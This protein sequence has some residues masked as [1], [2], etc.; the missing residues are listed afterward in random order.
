MKKEQTAI[1]VFVMTICLIFTI[2][3]SGCTF[4][5]SDQPENNQVSPADLVT[6][7]TTQQVQP[8]STQ[9][10]VS[11]RDYYPDYDEQTK[12]GL[13]EDAKDEIVRLFPN[14]ERSELEGYWQDHESSTYGPP[15]IVFANVD[16]TS[17]KYM[18]IQKIRWKGLEQ[19]IHNNIV[20]VK[21]DPGS[22][23]VVFYGRESWYKPLKEEIRTVSIEEA[24]DKVLEFVRNA[25]GNDFIE[26][27]E[28]DFYIC[29]IDVDSS[30]GMGL[31]YIVLFNTYGGVQY[32]NDQIYVQYDLIEDVVRRYRDELKDPGLMKNLTTLS[33]VPT[34]SENEAKR[35][36]ET[37]LKESYPGEDLNI[38]YRILNGH[39]NS[40]NWYDQDELVY[41]DQ[42]DPIRLIW[43]ITFSDSE[44]RKEDSRKTTTAI[45]DAHT[46]EIVSLNF[47]DIKIS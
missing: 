10:A 26:E 22:G 28:N 24:E 45:I 9:A 13:I 39:E 3:A 38:Q 46:G 8:E 5:E 17:E 4:L 34:I 14:V 41:A 16:D 32:L 40:L 35:L 44:M 19:N 36:L 21:V 33:P 18:E 27:K 37:K 11:W 20:A 2:L 47:R 15:G 6:A 23:D 7:Q 43:Y 25:K 31:A 12:S 42:P 29:K 1:L 30:S